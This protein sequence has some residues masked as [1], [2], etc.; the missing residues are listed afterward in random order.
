MSVVSGIPTTVVVCVV[1]DGFIVENFG[2]S[3][4]PSPYAVMAGMDLTS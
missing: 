2:S 4:P 1:V 3:P